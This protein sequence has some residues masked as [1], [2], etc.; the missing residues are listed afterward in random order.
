MIGNLSRLVKLASHNKIASRAVPSFYRAAQKPSVIN[1]LSLRN[2]NS[3]SVFHRSGENDQSLI[4]TLTD[5][6]KYE[7][8]IV[9]D[10][11]EPEFIKS[12]VEKTGFRIISNP[13]ESDIALEKDFG[14]E[15]I[16]VRFS[17][18]DIVNMNDD[19]NQVE[20]FE[21]GDGN[22]QPTKIADNHREEEKASDFH[23]NLI[24]TITKPNSPTLHFDLVAEE[25]E[26][27][28]NQMMFFNNPKIALEQTSEADYT[29]R[30][31]YIGP[32]FG[33]LSDD[34]KD[35]IDLFLEDRGIDTGLVMFMQD[36]IEFK[37][38][39]EYLHWLEQFSA[40]AKA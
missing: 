10:Q 34:L 9:E 6:V 31:S 25:G 32:V 29:R 40:F 2:F 21:E 7:K 37:E 15:K 5:E 23:V 13:G 36:Y 4:Q 20:V 1:C 11:G 33:Q 38:Q 39:G 30:G 14:N 24:L 22:Q 17:I 12:F 18:N 3:S 28:V 26:I 8:D 27:G 16:H 35:G 19:F